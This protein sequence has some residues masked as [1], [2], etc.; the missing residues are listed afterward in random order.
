MYDQMYEYFNKIL[1]EQQ[2]EFREGFGTQH[3]LLAMTEKWA[4]YLDKDWG[5]WALLTDLSKN[6]DCLI[7]NLLIAKLAAYGFD[8]ELLTLIQSYI[9]NRKQRTK[10]K[11]IYSTFL[12]LHLEFLKV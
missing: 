3:C 5:N 2:C 9:S 6:F 1:S 8:Y 11:N 10:V 7:L 4:K 12:T